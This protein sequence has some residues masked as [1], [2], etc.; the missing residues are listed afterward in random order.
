M[1][2]GP[3]GIAAKNRNGRAPSPPAHAD[4][5]AVHAHQ[6]IIYG[7][8]SSDGGQPWFEANDV[9]Q[10]D[11]LENLAQCAKAISTPIS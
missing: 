5:I 11:G 1:I 7:V 2:P 3:Y 4:T 6:G 9:S 8:P 10:E